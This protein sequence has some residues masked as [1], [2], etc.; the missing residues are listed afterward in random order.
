MSRVDSNWTDFGGRLFLYIYIY[1]YIYIYQRQV[2]HYTQN[3]DVPSGY[4]RVHV[5]LAYSRIRIQPQLAL[6]K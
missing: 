4:L 5:G 6:L 3:D 1:I 2:P